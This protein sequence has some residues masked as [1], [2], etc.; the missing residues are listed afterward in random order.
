MDRI[1]RTITLSDRGPIQIV[2]D[3]WTPKFV[4]RKLKDIALHLTLRTRKSDPNQCVVYAV[5]RK[6]GQTKPEFCAG[7][8][9]KESEISDTILDVVEEMLDLSDRDEWLDLQTELLSRLPAIAI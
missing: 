5:Q 6:K 9:C 8:L 4:T 2:E 1:K 7:Y 3:E